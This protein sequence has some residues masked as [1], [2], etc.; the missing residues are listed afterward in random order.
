MVGVKCGGASVLALVPKSSKVPLRVA[1]HPSS[2]D[3]I[4]TPL[5]SCLENKSGMVFPFRFPTT[6]NQIPI[7]SSSLSFGVSEGIWERTLLSTQLVRKAGH[8]YCEALEPR[9]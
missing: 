1:H 9:N 5:L 4:I 3:S 7:C 2:C 6:S 8:D